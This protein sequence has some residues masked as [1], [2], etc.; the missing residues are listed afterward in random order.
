[1]KKKPTSPAVKDDSKY[2]NFTILLFLTGYLLIDFMP[3]FQ[4]TEIIKPQ[5]LYLTVLNIVVA[6]YIYR[7]PKLHDQALITIFKRSYVFKAYLC[8]I[9][10]AALSIIGTKNLSLGVNAI[11]EILVVASMM[12][13]FSILL[14]KRLHLFYTLCFMVGLAAFF[15][16]YQAIY[17][18]KGLMT[19]HS[20]FEASNF[21]TYVEG[22]TGNIN[23]FSM[24]LMAKLPFLFIGI[25]H[26]SNW[27][28]WLLML[29]LLMSS[30][31]VFLI[32]ARASLLALLI[33]VVVFLLFYLRQHGSKLRNAINLAYVL[34][35]LM[36]SIGLINY[37]FSKNEKG[38]Y[39]STIGRFQQIKVGESST[40]VRLDYYRTAIDLTLENPVL[41]I[42]LG[43]WRVESLPRETLRN[44]IASLH[45]HNDFLEVFAT[46]GVLGG[47]F[48]LFV[49][50]AL[51]YLHVKRLWGRHE[52]QVAN[53]NILAFMV[54]LVYGIDATFNFPF[55]RPTMQL[56]FCLMVA[57]T[58]VSTNVVTGPIAVEFKKWR[59]ALALI[60]LAAFPL[61]FTYQADRTSQLEYKIIADNIN[62]SNSGKLT[63]DEIASFGP[64][65][66]NVFSTSESFDEYTG[67][68]YFR[69]K[70]Y[71]KAIAY[72]D[73]G[74]QINPYLGRPDFYK[75]LIA[76]ER[77]MVDS[78]AV[79]VMASFNRY[80][81]NPVIF[82]A[83]VKY[84]DKVDTNEVL[85]MYQRSAAYGNHAQIWLMA[86][87]ALQARKYSRANLEQF[88]ALG[89]REFPK[90]EMV[91][92]T[93][94]NTLISGY[95]VAGQELFA[96][97]KH[98]EALQF[99]EKAMAIDATDVF[100]LQNIGFYY[101]NLRQS[102]KA[103][104]YLKKALEKDGLTGGKTEYFLALC[105][106]NVK[107]QENACKYL[108]LA[109]NLAYPAA[110]TLFLQHCR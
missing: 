87:N 2:L 5:F 84:T 100:A 37:I 24:S 48:Y 105:Y 85:K 107:D 58:L 80:P 29:A 95:I 76:E 67:I 1:M 49:F 97:G 18:F 14:Y 59:L 45:T 12:I 38:R 46:T 44:G 32:N 92:A 25:M 102:A 54:L 82:N 47:L 31:L 86:V 74:N 64:L 91:K 39:T 52:E 4:R 23:I 50:L 41:G 20:I 109:R 22:N 70:K 77:G 8:F 65:F 99:Y 72:L 103:I 16:S 26:F 27:K 101:F 51:F 98:E 35:P 66:P 43:N 62:F 78:A 30:S 60:V 34:V 33:I 56:F 89:V 21:I 104:P 9:G 10:V 53:V 96:K 57:L 88:L 71:D 68:Y 69:E 15:Q 63:G 42:G 81:V 61:Y 11:A 17:D 93:Y 106:L 40:N 83:A 7:Q 36:L 3:Y 110:E 75:Y 13:N 19:G 28:R 6:L 79:Y 94:Q 73:R 108:T 55:Y 90:N